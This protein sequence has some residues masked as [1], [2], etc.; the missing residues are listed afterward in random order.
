MS[1]FKTEALVFQCSVRV[2]TNGLVALPETGSPAHEDCIL[3]TARER[4]WGG[5]GERA[6]AS[7]GVFS[8]SVVW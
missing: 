3:W 5:V 8:V 2:Q 7:A 6:T 4:D 1:A